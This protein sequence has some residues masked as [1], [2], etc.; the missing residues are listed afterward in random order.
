MVHSVEEGDDKHVF[1]V[2]RPATPGIQHS[3]QN[4]DQCDNQIES[5][6]QWSH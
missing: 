5:S 4:S 6:E 3:L 1:S 2:H